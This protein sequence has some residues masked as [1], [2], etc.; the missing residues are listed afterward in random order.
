MLSL[1]VA[2]MA[3]SRAAAVIFLNICFLIV[4]VVQI[5]L[6]KKKIKQSNPVNDLVSGEHHPGEEEENNNSEVAS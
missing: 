1:S 6:I 4:V 2:A 3:I 5:C